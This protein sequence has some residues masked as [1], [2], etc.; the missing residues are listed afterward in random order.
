M[1]LI[2][3]LLPVRSACRLEGSFETLKDLIKDSLFA[4]LCDVYD[5]EVLA[6]DDEGYRLKVAAKRLCVDCCKGVA[7]F[8]LE[9]SRE[10][11]SFFVVLLLLGCTL[12]LLHVVN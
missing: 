5:R 12:L 10:W 6:D 8:A 4:L 11:C 7:S 3:A 9:E 1:R 2:S